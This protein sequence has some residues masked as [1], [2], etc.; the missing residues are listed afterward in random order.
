MKGFEVRSSECFDVE[1]RA[2]PATVNDERLAEATELHSGRRDIVKTRKPE[3]LP[4]R[5]SSGTGISSWD[6][7]LS[8]A[9]TSLST[10]H[11]DF[12]SLSVTR[13]VGCTGL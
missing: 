10:S 5:R 2:V 13:D 11:L 1:S 8:L 4:S 6:R 7:V 3:D 12:L 9:A